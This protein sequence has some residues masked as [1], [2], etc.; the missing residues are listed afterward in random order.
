MRLPS[1]R[2]LRL[3]TGPT[4]YSFLEFLH[5]TELSGETSEDTLW[6]PSTPP[7]FGA[8]PERPSNGLALPRVRKE[9][10]CGHDGDRS[11]EMP[12]KR[13]PSTESFPFHSMTD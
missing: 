1:I 2:L 3:V 10:E 4:G 9:E 11:A 7:S 12:P 8:L 13:A 6:P 5:F